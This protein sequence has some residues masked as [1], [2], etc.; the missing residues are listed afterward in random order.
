MNKKI[1]RCGAALLCVSAIS[2]LTYSIT[3]NETQKP[4]GPTLDKHFAVQ[5]VYAS[6]PPKQPVDMHA[7]ITATLQD[8]EHEDIVDSLSVAVPEYYEMDLVDD[9]QRYVHD[10]CLAYDIEEYYRLTLALIIH[11]SQCDASVISNT[12]DY[13]LMQINKIN[14][15][16]LQEELGVDNMLDP[17]QNVEAGTYILQDLLKKYN[18]DEHAALMSYNMGESTAKRLWARGIY[19]SKYSREIVSIKESLSLKY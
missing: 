11:E 9:M 5:T 8:M 13:G 17:K 18:Y 7:G 15:S 1:K 6:Q 19:S 16:W 4:W 3:E 10:Q 14:H 2:A 12:N